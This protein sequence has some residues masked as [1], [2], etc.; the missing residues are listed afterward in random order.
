MWEPIL[1][2]DWRSPTSVTLARISDP[3]A[4]QFWDPHHLVSQELNRDL[5][6]DGV[7]LAGHTSRGS[8][9]DLAVLYP[10]GAQWR[11][12]LPAPSFVDG[13]VVTVASRIETKLR[14]LAA[15]P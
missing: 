3:R 6:A 10:Q 15:S 2:T 9:W 5:S 11:T 8:Y 1:P 13:A 12:V 7:P 14:G 4:V